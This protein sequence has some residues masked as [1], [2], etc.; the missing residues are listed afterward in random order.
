[1]ETPQTTEKNTSPTLNA[2]TKEKQSSVFHVL[3]L[4]SIITIGALGFFVLTENLQLKKNL[5][6]SP[7]QQ[8][9]NAPVPSEAQ[10]P[11]VTVTPAPTIAQTIKEWKE[12]KFGG[13]FTYEYP[14]GW[15]VAELWPAVQGQGIVIAMDPNPISTAPR[16]SG[17]A[18]FTFEVFNGL[19][20]PDKKL[21]EKKAEFKP[22]DY[23]DVKTETISSD[24]GDIFYSS[25]RIAGDYMQGKV[26]E[27]Y[28]FSLQKSASDPLNQQV[29]VAS[30]SLNTDPAVSE[31]FRKAVLSFKEKTQ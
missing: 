4:I 30:L 9:E 16:D 27:K 1:M 21:E 20:E 24:H 17:F 26:I 10:K 13:I 18:T 15:H 7:T 2:K 29:I 12:A 5:A 11:E 31:M 22:A 3:G 28:I 19:S 25:G 8:E 14:N 6:T 23:T